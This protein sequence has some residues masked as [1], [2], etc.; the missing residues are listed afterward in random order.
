M[1][2]SQVQIVQAG[3]EHVPFIAWVM[4]VSHRS[5]LELGFWDHLIGGGDEGVRRY[6]E[7]LATTQ[8]RHWAHYSTF[9][10]AH[11]DGLATS[12]LCGYF[13]EE[14]G[15]VNFRAGLEE[16]NLKAGRTEDEVAAGWARAGSILNVLPEHVPGA[17]I[18]EHV[19]T[20]PEFRRQGLV[21][22]L[23]HEMLER[24]AAR[25][26]STADISVLIGNDPA[27]RA[28]EKCGFKMV[29]EKRD[30]A[31]GEAY[32]TPGIRTLRRPL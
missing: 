8:R 15:G 25:G 5:H 13:E 31:F 7:V 30:P 16:A 28:Y 32:G 26:A 22:R 20:R 10:V 14:S 24:G 9:L 29:A 11:V 6:L 12:A 23:L 4:Q 1:T 27:Q 21:E 3:P 2:T 18:V 19:A 17:W